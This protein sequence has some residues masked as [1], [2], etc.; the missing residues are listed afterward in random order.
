MIGFERGRGS[1]E[2]DRDIVYLG[3]HDGR[4]ATVEPRRRIILLVGSIVL[5]IDNYQPRIGKR[6]EHRRA[7]PDHD[8]EPTVPDTLPA[9]KPLALRHG[10]VNYRHQITEKSAKVRQSRP[11]ESNLRG[12]H[13]SRLALR[14]NIT[15]QMAVYHRLARP[16]HAMQ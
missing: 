11:G 4:I 8:L 7:R 13:Q 10:R 2:N 16:G 1:A 15:A 6:R 12:E 3:A 9:I 5:L 14:N